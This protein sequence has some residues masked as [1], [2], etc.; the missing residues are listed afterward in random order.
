MQPTNKNEVD[1]FRLSFNL[2]KKKKINSLALKTTH[3]QKGIA[4]GI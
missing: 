4:C 3:I 1:N 2:K